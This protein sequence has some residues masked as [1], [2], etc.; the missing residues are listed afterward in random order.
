MQKRT[1]GILAV[2]LAVVCGAV[3]VARW[4]RLSELWASRKGKDKADETV[5]VDQAKVARFIEL[6]PSVVE[7]NGIRTAPVTKP[8]RKRRLELR[9]QL[10]FDPDSMVH[11]HGRFPGQIVSLRQVDEPNAE[12]HT[13]S[14]KTKR[15]IAV[16]DHVVQGQE[17]GI[18]WSKE[19]GE[20]KSELVSSLIRLRVDRQNLK[21]TLRTYEE[22]AAPERT[23]REAT[24][25]VEQD[26]TDVEKARMTLRSWLL[27][28]P[29]IDEVAAEA[30][31]IH[32]E[33]GERIVPSTRIVQVENEW[34]RVKIEAPR[35]GTIVEKN[36]AVGTIVDTNT[37]LFKIADLSR[38]RVVA[39]VYEEDLRYLE[40][41]PRQIP[42]TIT[43]N[44]MPGMEPINGFVEHLGAVID[45]AEHVALVFGK[46]DN[47]RGELVAGQFIKAAIEL[48]ELPN[49][50][51]IPTRALV[52]D[53]K[54]SVVLVRVDKTRFRYA[55]RRVLVVRRYHDVVRVRS[56]LTD[57]EREQGLEELHEGEEV[58][59][60]GALDLKAA[61]SQQESLEKEP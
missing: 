56:T 49:V 54:E 33:R 3:A 14:L 59:A 22:G 39:N 17:I 5:F 16:M 2:V 41:M 27:S 31:R 44:S 51:E 47:P 37:D 21:Q 30:D 13:Q 25:L 60:V 42:W 26:E 10:D 18:L 50:V 8:T 24:R 32:R 28:S 55:P 48:P 23:V 40:Q 36:V 53:G 34:A 1:I 19:L 52:E 11:V 29:E 38:L 7:L 20:K 61:L 12:L 58:V 46:V 6:L 9:G 45:P 4:P 35:K 15:D 57:A 43:V